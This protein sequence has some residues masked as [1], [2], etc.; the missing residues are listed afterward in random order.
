MTH[1]DFYI[2]HDNNRQAQLY[3]ACR[4]IEKAHRLGQD[5]FIACNTPAHAEELNQ[6]LWTYNPESFI[7]HALLSANNNEIIEIGDI[8]SCGQH[9]QLLINLSGH[10]PDYFSRFERLIEIV[11]QDENM[12]QYTR[13]HW[14]HYKQRGYPINAHNIPKELSQSLQRQEI[15]AHE[16]R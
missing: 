7:P 8:T 4:L 1:I 14:A 15:R 10:I 12:L 13:E 6:L 9:H 5:I 16:H 3:F 11:V 2:L